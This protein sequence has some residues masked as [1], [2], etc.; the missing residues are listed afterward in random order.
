MSSFLSYSPSWP[1]LIWSLFLVACC[2]TQAACE[3]AALEPACAA[4][5]MVRTLSPRWLGAAAA[6][7]GPALGWFAPAAWLA[8]AAR[9]AAAE[10]LAALRLAP[11]LAAAAAVFFACI[12]VLRF[13]RHLPG[14]WDPSGHVFL[15]GVTLMPSWVLAVET[16]HGDAASLRG[17]GAAAAVTAAA[18]TAARLTEPLL[19]WLSAGAATVFHT[20][21]EVALPW[22]AAAALAA[23]TRRLA[24]ADASP[25]AAVTAALCTR[26]LTAG[27][28]AW[29]GALVA[30][31]AAGALHGPLPL[32]LAHDAALA[33]LAAALLW[34][35][36][37]A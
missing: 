36:A 35:V 7:A 23:A 30:F 5:A 33:A 31:S 14:G 20:P 22:A 21:S 26:T 11:A 8:A 15:V 19:W 29:L 18:A 2:L 1:F 10:R 13:A 6:V 24:A 27:V 4:Q 28:V 12:N 3:A 25:A 9:G 32:F 17:A 16:T 34:R 37:A